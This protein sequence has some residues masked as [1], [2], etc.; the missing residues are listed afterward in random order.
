M[1]TPPK[2]YKNSDGK[3][4][5]KINLLPSIGFGAFRCGGISA[6]ASNEAV[7]KAHAAIDSDPNQYNNHLSNLKLV[8]REEGGGRMTD[9]I[10][11]SYSEMRHQVSPLEGKFIPNEAVVILSASVQCGKTS[12]KLQGMLSAGI[13]N[14]APSIFMVKDS[15]TEVDKMWNA[16]MDFNDNVAKVHRNLFPEEYH[17]CPK[18]VPLKVTRKGD[19]EKFMKI[20]KKMYTTPGY[21]KVPVLIG[22]STA[23]NTG[24]ISKFMSENASKFKRDSKNACKV[25]LFIDEGDTIV[26]KDI[27]D[28]DGV[29]DRSIVESENKS[30]V[31]EIEKVL[32]GT[33]QIPK[34]GGG[35]SVDNMVLFEAFTTCVVVSATTQS[36]SYVGVPN[37]GRTRYLL[38]LIP[39]RNY[40]GIRMHRNGEDGCVNVIQP[41]IHPGKMMYE[42]LVDNVMAESEKN[43][44]SLICMSGGGLE[45]V[46]KNKAAGL[47]VDSTLETDQQIFHAKDLCKEK[48]LPGN[49]VVTF[50]W[51]AKNFHVFTRSVRIS[52][53]IDSISEVIE[54]SDSDREL[55]S[56][57]A[58]FSDFINMR[59]GKDPS[60]YMEKTVWGEGD[61]KYFVYS[62]KMTSTLAVDVKT[63]CDSTDIESKKEYEVGSKMLSTYIGFLTWL[64]YQLD[65]P[66]VDMDNSSLKFFIFALGMFGRGITGA[67]GHHKLAFTDVFVN[68]P[69]LIDSSLIQLTG[70]I[71]KIQ[72]DFEG[73]NNL[74]CPKGTYDRIARMYSDMIYMLVLFGGN[75]T[76]VRRETEK[77]RSKLQEIPRV[78]GGKRRIDDSLGVGEKWFS[79]AVTHSSRV[80]QS[81][82]KHTNAAVRIIKKQKKAKDVSC[83]FRPIMS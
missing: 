27:T 31:S 67:S 72:Y 8:M 75:N 16:A 62:S 13:F 44:L 78:S 41:E 83:H 1:A 26:K 45:G 50:A 14:G 24:L 11:N 57:I 25:F 81:V 35:S 34:Y 56:N 64:Q 48:S 30:D 33:V 15:T 39:S 9:D 76:T 71:C 63:E 38:E 51:A 77:M 68:A 29:I 55:E 17:S 65:V 79:G 23:M 7:V 74:W 12:V 66:G 6:Q 21:N 54:I 59:R 28:A 19:L 32:F 42:S 61:N 22:M 47:K 58:L 69:G 36:I 20:T 52:E 43:R 3:V 37:G 53:M 73:I 10:F 82:C 60:K 80:G 5:S 4:V 40:V 18:L 46:N 70:R 2:D 49:N